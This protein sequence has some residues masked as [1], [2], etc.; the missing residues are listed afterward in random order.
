MSAPLE[1]A[2]VWLRIVAI[3]SPGGAVTM[4]SVFALRFSVLSS[5]DAVLLPDDRA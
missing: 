1:I 5:D 4:W 2:L 3:C